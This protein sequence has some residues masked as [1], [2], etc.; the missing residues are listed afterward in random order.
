MRSET[1]K[2]KSFG[3]A[4]RAGPCATSEGPYPWV[5]FTQLTSAPGLAPGRDHSAD[6]RTSYQRNHASRRT[7]EIIAFAHFPEAH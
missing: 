7:L 4:R 5:S 3:A 1:P 6:V 2:Q